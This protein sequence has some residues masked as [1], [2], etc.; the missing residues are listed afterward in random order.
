MEI[1]ILAKTKQRKGT[2][3]ERLMKAVLD[4]LGYHN[5]R[6]R[7]NYVGM[8][9]DI[10]A[11]HK[12]TSEPLL[13]ECKAHARPIG[14]QALTD[15][16]GKVS[17]KRSKNSS[18]K[19]IFASL[20]GYSANA[21]E[22]YDEFTPQDKLVNTLLDNYQ[23]LDL[24]RKSGLLISEQEIDSKM[25]SNTNLNLGERY[26][27]YTESGVF[28]VQILLV[29]GRP[30]HYLLLTGKGELVH[31]TIEE[32]IAKLD[33]T[34]KSLV[35]IDLQ[36][37]DSV[38]IN[39]LDLKKKSIAQISREINQTE[40]D[41]SIA[42]EELRLSKILNQESVN[43]ENVF[44]MMTDMET[45]TKLTLKY[46]FSSRKYDFMSSAYVENT[47]NDAFGVYVKDRYKLALD[48]D[49]TSMLIVVCRIFPSILYFTLLGDNSSYVRNHEHLEELRKSGQKFG[50]LE[51]IIESPFFE[52]IVTH[53]RS[54]M[55]SLDSNYLAKN[56]GI[57]GF[58]MKSVF[59]MASEK[60]LIFSIYTEGTNLF[61]TAGGPIEAGSLLSATDVSLYLNIA[62]VLCAL[63]LY[64]ESIR[65]FDELIRLAT[66]R[67]DLLKAAWNN[68]GLCYK[69]Q[70]KYKEAIQCY[71][72]ALKIDP[73]L[74]QAL[75]N[76]AV[77]Y[78]ELGEIKKAE[79]LKK[80]IVNLR[81]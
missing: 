37:L 13:C 21:L 70:K 50:H 10:K 30:S 54:D 28:I 79:E 66:G 77:C 25:S 6:T 27:V 44:S 36:I 35:K 55:Q 41:V 14:P 46:A 11:E 19:G 75:S 59:K 76:L 67:Q 53:I 45:L 69:A 31:K 51:N 16:F 81:T 80:K 43:G 71:E 2:L 58:F 56:K 29:G 26:L 23:I 62:N 42:I 12:V 64:D 5:F 17:I 9:I 68:K 74:V 49:K 1:R 57:Q 73:N 7:I 32:E 52:R 3:F 4:V 48:R 22:M 47:V 38:T 61:A 34:I 15:F 60:Q 78:Q 40:N 18:L 39:L 72:E 8:E 63:E 20:S 33:K 24:L 65:E